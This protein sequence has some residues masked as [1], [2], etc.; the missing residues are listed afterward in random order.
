MWFGES[1][2]LG[3]LVLTTLTTSLISESVTHIS[4][5]N[6]DVG[7][8]GR[9][10]FISCGKKNRVCTILLVDRIVITIERKAI[11]EITDKRNFSANEV[12]MKPTFLQQRLSCRLRY[13]LID[14]KL[15]CVSLVLNNN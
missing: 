6:E 1:P 15:W 14:V 8:R 11:E 7:R 3:L 13:C 12:T 2:C 4:S 9:S 5:D 10:N